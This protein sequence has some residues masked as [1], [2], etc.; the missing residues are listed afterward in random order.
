MGA[1]E[2]RVTLES[3]A[4]EFWSAARKLTSIILPLK[5]FLRSEIAIPRLLL[6][7]HVLYK[8]YI[9]R[10][11]RIVRCFSLLSDIVKTLEND[12]QFPVLPRKNSYRYILL[13]MDYIISKHAVIPF[14]RPRD[15]T[16][17]F[18]MRS[19]QDREDRESTLYTYIV[20]FWRFL[21]RVQKKSICSFFVWENL[22]K[23]S[24]ELILILLFDRI[25]S[26][27]LDVVLS[28]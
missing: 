10:V 8:R 27:F 14:A 24:F 21:S 12:S 6:F 25:D 22:E 11:M 3:E 13:K 4:E 28:F 26:N 16:F 1:S 7:S 20:K 18:S 19:C 23:I 2:R 5:S 15:F 9:V 17:T